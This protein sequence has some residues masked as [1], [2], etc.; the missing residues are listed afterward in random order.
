[1]KTLRNLQLAKAQPASLPSLDVAAFQRDILL[2]RQIQK[3]QSQIMQ[4]EYILEDNR[5]I[6]MKDSTEQGL[7]VYNIFKVLNDLGVSEGLGYMQLKP[8]LPR[9]GKRER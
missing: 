5:R 3:I 8:Y 9:T 6:L 7:Y 4:L 2:I 1:M